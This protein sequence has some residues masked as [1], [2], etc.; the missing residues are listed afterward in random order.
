MEQVNIQSLE[1]SVKDLIEQLPEIL[2]EASI[3]SSNSNLQNIFTV[4]RGGIQ[5]G[6]RERFKQM[7]EFMS[8]LISS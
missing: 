2:D 5:E 6:A 7:N 8:F 3:V 4:K 1:T